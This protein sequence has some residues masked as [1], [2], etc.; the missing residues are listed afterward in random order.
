MVA[1]L[2]GDIWAVERVGKHE[3]MPDFCLVDFE[4]GSDTVTARIAGG[5]QGALCYDRVEGGPG[6]VG[7]AFFRALLCREDWLFQGQV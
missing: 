6:D 2:Q 3:A 7:G 4:S 1:T 5:T